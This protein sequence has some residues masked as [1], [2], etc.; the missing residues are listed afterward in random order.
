MSN[1][2]RINVNNPNL[3]RADAVQI[4]KDDAPAPTSQG[5]SQGRDSIA[6]SGTARAL[7]RLAGLVHQSRAERFAE[8]QRLLESGAYWVSGEDIAARMIESN[9]K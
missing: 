9:R 6:L 7:D 3:E 8:V 4:K 5:A 1:I 2:N